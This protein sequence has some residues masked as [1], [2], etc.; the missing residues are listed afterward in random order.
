VAFALFFLLA[1]LTPAWERGTFTY[2]PLVRFRLSGRRFQVGVL[3]LLPVLAV[4]SWFVARLVERPRRAWRWGPAHLTLPLVL[5]VG[6]TLVRAWPVHVGQILVIVA[7]AVLLYLGVYLYV[8]Q[9]WPER[10]C[11]ALVAGF[12][13][14]QGG[15]AVTQFLRQGSVGLAWMGEASLAPEGQ[16]ISVVEAGGRRWLRAYGLSPHPNLL[17]GYLG[18]SLL[19][20]LGAVRTGRRWQRAFLATAIG[21]GALGLFASFS[22]SAW[23][24]TM[25]GLV[26]LAWLTRPWQAVNWQS[27]RVQKVMLGLGALLLAGA[28]GL[29]FIYRDLLSAR[30]LR[31]SSPLE[32]TS[33]RERL[34]DYRQ[35]WSLIR[36]VPLKGVGSGYYIPALWAGVGEDRPPGFRRVHSAYLLAAAELGVGG[37]LVWI[38]TFL[39]PPV[40]LAWRAQRRKFPRDGWNAA[41]AGWA[42]AFVCA[43]VLCLFD[44]YL[45]MP[46]TWWAALY[47]ALVSGAYAGAVSSRRSGPR[48]Q[49]PVGSEKA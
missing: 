9:E 38:W 48:T 1:M 23:L 22:R 3:A 33:I 40:A 25:L 2:L 43:L 39:A 15:I 8:L 36:T 14:L 6:W 11:V 5:S 12:L 4:S 7:V 24:G 46:S 32:A 18:M 17:G 26:Y 16:G 20:S 42:A 21:V 10:W 34:E 19:A 29:G 27:R 49:V 45:Y 31:L 35:A 41:G 13:V 28:L 30:F 47:L 37:A 44:S